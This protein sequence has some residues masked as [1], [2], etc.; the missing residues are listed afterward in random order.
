MLS[1]KISFRQSCRGLK[2]NLGVTPLCIG[3]KAGYNINPFTVFNK[4]MNVFQDTAPQD[5]VVFILGYLNQ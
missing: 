3:V 4:I 1:T 2:S 5:N